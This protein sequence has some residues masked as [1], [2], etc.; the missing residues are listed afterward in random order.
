[1]DIQPARPAFSTRVF[2]LDELSKGE[3]NTLQNIQKDVSH[4]I[5]FTPG[6][7]SLLVKQGVTTAAEVYDPGTRTVFYP[8]NAPV[9]DKGLLDAQGK[10]VLDIADIIIKATTPPWAQP[11]PPNLVALIPGANIVVGV[12]WCYDKLSHTGRQERISGAFCMAN[13]VVQALLFLGKFFSWLQHMANW[14]IV[15][16]IGIEVGDKY[17]EYKFNA[18]AKQGRAVL[19]GVEASALAASAAVRPVN[20]LDMLA[21][22]GPSVSTPTQKTPPAL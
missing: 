6:V 2:T 22:S 19:E 9:N 15:V 20:G 21:P 3:R 17:V 7:A 11:V 10:L 18:G 13:R 8:A 12:R 14:L 5:Y 16:K 4:N 1:M